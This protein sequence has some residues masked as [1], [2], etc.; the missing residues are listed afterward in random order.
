MDED[1]FDLDE[2]DIPLE[3]VAEAHAKA[4]QA[5]AAKKAADGRGTK[6]GEFTKL[7][8]SWRVRLQ[9]AHGRTYD[10]ALHL[11]HLSFK[12]RGR[13][14]KLANGGLAE[15]G[16]SRFAKRRALRELERRSLIEVQRNPHKNPTIT[17]RV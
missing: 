5:K 1:P 15:I 16:I 9:G 3:M 17:L 2:L 8:S 4:A 14:F 12:A 10:L 11:L 7:P 6:N 13:P